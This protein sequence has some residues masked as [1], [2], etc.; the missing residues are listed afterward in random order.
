MKNHSFHKGCHLVSVVN[1]NGIEGNNY[2]ILKGGK[3]GNDEDGNHHEK[4]G[5][6][7]EPYNVFRKTAESVADAATVKF[8]RKELWFTTAY[9]DLIA[10]C[11]ENEQ[12]GYWESNGNKWVD[13]RVQ[14]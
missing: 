6:Y 7:M 4:Y 5:S 11:A 10:V 1:G 13:T 2:F 12:L 14:K 3:T 9:G 8:D